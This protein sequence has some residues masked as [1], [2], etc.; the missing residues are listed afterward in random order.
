TNNGKLGP[1]YYIAPEMLNPSI[2]TDY[3]KADVYSL[4]KSLWVLLTNQTYPIPGEH[5]LNFK[6]I[7]LSSF[8]NHPRIGILDILLNRATKIDP[9][10]RIDMEEFNKELIAWSNPVKQKANKIDLKQ[11]L[12]EINYFL[13]PNISEE[14]QRKA[15]VD[16]IHQVNDS[17]RIDVQSA[18]DNLESSMVG[19]LQSGSNGSVIGKNSAV[20]VQKK[21][22]DLI[23][24]EGYATVIAIENPIRIYLWLFWGC[25]AF[26]DDSVNI[27]VG[28]RIQVGMNNEGE[29]IW[30]SSKMGTAKSSQLENF[31]IELVQ[32][33]IDR[34]PLVFDKFLEELKNFS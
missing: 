1:I 16:F 18:L 32:E 26:T 34:I 4:A 33:F 2:L 17:I 19:I 28:S 5:D 14:I 8:V 3:R 13:Q 9:K 29:N 30:V 10:T 21:Q 23:D 7:H 31:R 25:E 27:I 24:R 11:I 12:E 6:S 22:K 20:G 15:I